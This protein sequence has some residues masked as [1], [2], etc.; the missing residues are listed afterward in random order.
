MTAPHAT[1]QE[2]IDLPSVT[3]LDEAR[4]R[5]IVA[6]NVPAKGRLWPVQVRPVVFPTKYQDGLKFKRDTQN[7]LRLDDDSAP[8]RR[9]ADPYCVACRASAMQ[10]TDHGL[11]GT[12]FVIDGL[13]GAILKKWRCV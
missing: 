7:I 5:E 6:A 10:S 2:G 4:I 13:T 11:V 9:K 8:V 3:L 1:V 12:E